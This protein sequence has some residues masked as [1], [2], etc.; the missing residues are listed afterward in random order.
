MAGNPNP[1]P[2]PNPD[3]AENPIWR[4]LRN[5]SWSLGGKAVG[6]V[7]SI[8]YLAMIAR[9]LGPLEFGRFALI[10]S[11][12]QVICGLVA[13]PTWQIIIR[14]GTKYVLDQLRDKFAQLVWL[15]LAMDLAGLCIGMILTVAAL[16][17]FGGQFGINADLRGWIILFVSVM[18]LS[19]RGTVIGILRAH[20][21]FRDAAL[22]DSLVPLI[23]FI[24]VI[25]VVYIRPNVESFLLI[26]VLSEI[27]TTAILWIIAL[28]S[29]DLPLAAQKLRLIP[30][31]YRQYPDLTRF[32]GFSNLGTSLRVLGQQ[33]IVLIV[34]LYTGP[35][36]AGFF[37]LGHQLGQVL[38]RISDG[39]SVAFYAEHNRMSHLDADSA[40]ASMIARTVK[41]MAISAAVL[42]AILLAF[43]K[44][45]LIS[46]FGAPFAP[47]YP[48]VILLGGAAAVQ[49]G[50]SALEPILLAKGNAGWAL[51]ANLI[52]SITLLIVLFALIPIYDA[53]GASIAVLIG[54]IV[55]TIALT[56]FYRRLR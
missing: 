6:A 42:L 3:S 36:S 35:A 27:A 56:I 52:G 18:L 47:A 9:S 24:G 5:T 39:L 40:V 7:L 11:F 2:N 50:S 41:V 19:V 20:D 26:W 33:F 32:T 55:S 51:L 37:R 1:N 17:G 53:L 48:F 49:L 16:Y 21:R 4:I 46:I 30:S 45:L 8:V 34:G 29:L 10:F 14:Y 15:C 22:A 43:G 12:A 25:L 23:R 31:Y 54:A 13:F 28:I 38:A 44:L